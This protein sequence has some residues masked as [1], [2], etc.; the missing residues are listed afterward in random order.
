MPEMAFPMT[1][2]DYM[3]NWVDGRRRRALLV[4]STSQRE[5]P[6]IELSSIPQTQVKAGILFY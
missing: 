1:F 4:K 2:L 5:I 6:C 3:V